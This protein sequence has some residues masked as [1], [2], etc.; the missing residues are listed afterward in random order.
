M[1]ARS[2]RLQ[3]RGPCRT[4]TDLPYTTNDRT[5]YCIEEEDAVKQVVGYGAEAEVR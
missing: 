1:R 2:F 3:W 5:L 4:S